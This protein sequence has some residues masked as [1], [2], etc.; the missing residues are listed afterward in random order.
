MAIRDVTGEE[1]REAVLNSGIDYIESHDCGICREYVGYRI[2][3]KCLF[4]DGSCGCCRTGPQ[5]RD[6]S[7]LS[8]WVNMQDGQNKID[9]AAKVKVELHA[10]NES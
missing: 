4:W 6:W 7:T 3:E 9:I 8:D 1:V 5:L 10:D 2:I